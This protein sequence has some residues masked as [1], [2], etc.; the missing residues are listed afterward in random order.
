MGKNQTNVESFLINNV[1]DVIYDRR[2]CKYYY[3]KGGEKLLLDPHGM[4][5]RGNAPGY[6]IVY[7]AA[8][9]KKL[10]GGEIPGVHPVRRWY[11]DNHQV[12][13]SDAREITVARWFRLDEAR[14]I[15][16]IR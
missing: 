2:D 3:K 1:N 4:V 16:A 12:N 6:P 15:F 11:S 5:V 14:K 10:R 7:V 9:D 8:N 13:Y